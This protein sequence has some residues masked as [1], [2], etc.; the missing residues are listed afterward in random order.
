MIIWM[1]GSP[2]KALI[3][4]G[5]ASCVKNFKTQNSHILLNSLDE[6]QINDSFNF[7][8]GILW[9]KLNC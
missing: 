3:N 8:M 5:A 4:Q 7:Y 1:L 6:F 9:E 2:V